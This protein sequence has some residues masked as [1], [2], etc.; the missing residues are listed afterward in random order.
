[1]YFDDYI[2]TCITYIN[3]YEDVSQKHFLF[4]CGKVKFVVLFW[5]RMGI[6]YYYLAAKEDAQF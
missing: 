1:M 5:N 2:L 3:N 6:G 4:S